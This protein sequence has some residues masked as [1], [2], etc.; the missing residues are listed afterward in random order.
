MRTST[1]TLAMLA[2]LYWSESARVW[3]ALGCRD[4]ARRSGRYARG[5]LDLW[6]KLSALEVL[7]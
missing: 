7:P 3:I 1:A 5:W 2:W 6:R 4:D